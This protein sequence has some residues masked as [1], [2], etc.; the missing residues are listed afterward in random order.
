MWRG[1][2]RLTLIVLRLPTLHLGRHPRGKLVGTAKGKLLA[3]HPLLL[4]QFGDDL[5][6]L[7]YGLHFYGG[8]LAFS[9]ALKFKLQRRLGQGV[10]FAGLACDMREAAGELF[11][12]NRILF[13]RSRVGTTWKRLRLLRLAPC[14]RLPATSLPP[15]NDLK[16][17]S[18]LP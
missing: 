15:Q 11:N 6:R 17:C 10:G 1:T 3:A 14:E 2:K 8:R 9:T 4:H 18:A 5:T 16:D 12:V 13:E 7:H